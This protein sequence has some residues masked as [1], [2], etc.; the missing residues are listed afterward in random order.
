MKSFLLLALTA[1][2]LS[3][4]AANAETY[5]LL[6]KHGEGSKGRSYSWRIPT[7]SEAE[8]NKEKTKAVKRENWEAWQYDPMS[9]LSAICIKGK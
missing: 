1:G 4:S 3:P 6:I 2:L 5:W 7:N 9:V 8:C